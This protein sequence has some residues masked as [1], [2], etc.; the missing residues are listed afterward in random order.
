MT[1][2]EAHDWL[3]FM[4]KKTRTGFFSRGKKDTA[5]HNAQL[6]VFATYFAEFLQTQYVHE[7]LKPFREETDLTTNATGY[8][9]YPSGYEHATGAMANYYDNELLQNFVTAL[10]LYKSD[11]LGDALSSQVRPVTNQKPI[12]VLKK[13]GIQVYP[14]TAVYTVTLNYLSTPVK[15]FYSYTASGTVETHD[16]NTST[17]PQWA[18]SYMNPVLM[19]ALELLGVNLKQP[20]IVQY[21]NEKTVQN[22]TSPVK[23]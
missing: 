7:A 3:D 10:K 9:A 14:K 19:K 11:E 12:A 1:I 15:P 5:I 22:Q 18:D 6:G 4:L 8:V 13:A 21:A 23:I 17:N 20:E 16:P 2:K